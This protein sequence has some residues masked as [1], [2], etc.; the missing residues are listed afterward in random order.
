MKKQD[1]LL[2]AKIEEMKLEIVGDTRTLEELKKELREKGHIFNSQTDTE[3]IPHLI[4]EYGKNN[5]F[6]KA[7]QLALKKLDG[8]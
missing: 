6:E 7:V 1:P 3:V 2:T 8:S 4:E 5:D